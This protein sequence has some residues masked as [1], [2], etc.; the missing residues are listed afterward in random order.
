[1]PDLGDL[2]LDVAICAV[3]FVLTVI[4]V[5]GIYTGD[6]LIQLASAVLSAICVADLI[7]GN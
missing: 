1:M 4:G 6:A 7:K 3:L 5:Y 2:F